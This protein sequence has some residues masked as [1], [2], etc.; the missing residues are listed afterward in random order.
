MTPHRTAFD[1]YKVISPRNVHLGDGSVVEAIVMG[2]IIVG[3][4]M[5][6][7][8]TTMCITNVFHVP[9]LHKNLLLVSKFLSKG[10][11]VQFHVNKWMVGGA[12]GDVVA[13]TQCKGNL[14]QM[15]FMK[16][17]GAYSAD[18]VH[19]RGR[20]NSIELW[21]HQLGHLFVRSIYAP[22]NMVK[23]IN[24]GKTSPPIITFICKACTEG[25]QYV[26]KRGNNEEKLTIE[27]L[28]IMHWGVCGPIRTISI[29]KTNNFM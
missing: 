2:S 10:L 4:E 27:P 9:K 19:S 8:T 18:F 1:T 24:L 14:Y 7:K 12:N 6:R 13:K 25:K 15:T 22:Q 20:D 23:D 3:A 28:E 5:K 21:H 11:K 17:C 26:A 16:V 29:G